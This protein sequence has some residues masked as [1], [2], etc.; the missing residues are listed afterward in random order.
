MTKLPKCLVSLWL[1]TTLY[2]VL[3]TFETLILYKYEIRWFYGTKKRLG[4][5]IYC[6]M[7][8]SHFGSWHKSSEWQKE[9]KFANASFWFIDSNVGPQWM[10]VH[11]CLQLMDA[12]HLLLPVTATVLTSTRRMFIKYSMKTCIWLAIIDLIIFQI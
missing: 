7:G 4:C 2:I 12:T 9:K 10:R 5:K 6:S 1:N 11:I 8:E 3:V